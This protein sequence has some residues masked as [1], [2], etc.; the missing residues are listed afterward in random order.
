[1]PDQFDVFLSHNSGDK[2]AVEKIAAQLR[3]TGLR[4]WLDKWELRPGFPWQE[5]LEEGVRSSR[6]VA[7]FV[8]SSGLGAWQEPEM[9]ASLTR[10]RRERIPVIP[11]LLPGCPESPQLNIFLE[12]LTWVDLREGVS[13]DGFSRLV[14]GITGTKADSTKTFATVGG[15]DSEPLAL[16][17]NRASKTRGRWGWGVGLALLSAVLVLILWLRARSTE[18]DAFPNQDPA[19]SAEV[20]PTMPEPSP[21]RDQEPKETITK[22]SPVAAKPAIYAVRVQVLDPQ[23]RPVNES[24]VRASVGNEPQ[25]ISGGGWEIEIPA[26]KVPADGRISLWAE[27]KDW[28]ENRV[29]LRLGND[30]NL[31]AEIRLKEPETW[32]QGQVTDGAGRAVSGARV[33]RQDGSSGVALTDEEGRYKLRLPLPPGTRVRLGAES[34]GLPRGD[35]F[36]YAGEDCPIPLEER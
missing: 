12:N 36:C 26:A 2:P 14:W 28:E 33:Y 20:R 18:P 34:A 11:V 7:V 30:P 9:Q 27:H 35:V 8:G 22:P 24:T 31:Q 4:V 6:A 23:G 32:L 1:M 15:G 16:H 10:S 3:A 29:D 13:E 19:P 25:Q 5:G 21:R 17:S